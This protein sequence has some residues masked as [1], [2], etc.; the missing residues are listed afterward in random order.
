MDIV[1]HAICNQNLICYPAEIIIK[2]HSFTLNE[3][4]KNCIIEMSNS[5]ADLLWF[6]NVDNRICKSSSVYP[7]NV[8]W[9][10]AG[11]VM[12]A[13]Q[14]IIPIHSLTETYL[15]LCDATRHRLM[16]LIINLPSLCYVLCEVM[17][18]DNESCPF[19]K[20]GQTTQKVKKYYI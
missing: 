13:S 2:Y 6:P 16:N 7:L 1:L 19:L 11:H 18:L 10:L 9:V 8:T 3:R 5:E 17:E 15:L 14:E 4:S 12:P 20:I